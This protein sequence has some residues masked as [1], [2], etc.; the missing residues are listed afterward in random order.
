VE[1]SALPPASV[2]NPLNHKGTETQRPDPWRRSVRTGLL[3][4]LVACG[5]SLLGTLGVFS[6]DPLAVSQAQ[7]KR[8]PSPSTPLGTLSLSKGKVEGAHARGHQKHVS[9]FSFQ[10]F[11][12]SAFSALTLVAGLNGRGAKYA[13]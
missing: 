4:A 9:G 11:S 5:E 3:C 10:L 13:G 1:S 2:P 8:A 6:W 12:R 7:K